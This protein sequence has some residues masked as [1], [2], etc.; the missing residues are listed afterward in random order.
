MYSLQ[1][2][3]LHGTNCGSVVQSIYLDMGGTLI[4]HNFT[5]WT[6]APQP[7]IFKRSHAWP[8]VAATP[9]SQSCLNDGLWGDM[10]PRWTEDGQVLT[11]FE[12][13]FKLYARGSTFL[14]RIIYIYL[15]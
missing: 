13:S 10:V 9:E 12:S 4:E 2:A 3:F 8:C 6:N 1:V 5:D 7:Q 14:N 15:Y 11:F